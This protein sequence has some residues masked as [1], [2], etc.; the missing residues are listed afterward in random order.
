ELVAFLPAPVVA[1][2]ALDALAHAAEALMSTTANPL[3]EG[4]S[5]QAIELVVTN[6]QQAYEGDR[7]ARGR[8]LRAAYHAGLA[9][10]SG[11]VLGHSLGYAINHEKPLPHGTTT[12]LA[13]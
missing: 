3:T 9:L 11:V 12:G 4:Q 8:L 2:T 13:L 10:N 6:I 1:S 7:A 5:A